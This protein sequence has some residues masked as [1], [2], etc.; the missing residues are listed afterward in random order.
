MIKIDIEKYCEEC[1]GF[2]VEQDANCVFAPDGR[3]LFVKHTISCKHK[4]KCAQIRNYLEQYKINK[5]NQ[6]EML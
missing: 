3:T 2:G 1:P 4:N 6:D 5:E